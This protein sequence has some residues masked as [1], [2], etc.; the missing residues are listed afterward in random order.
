MAAPLSELTVNSVPVMPVFVI[1][2][3]F[4]TDRG[5]VD[6]LVQG[7]RKVDL[8]VGVDTGITGPT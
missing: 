6:R 5:R 4:Y 3:I 8:A 1:T 7:H 2:E